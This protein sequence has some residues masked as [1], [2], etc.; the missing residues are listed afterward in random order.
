MITSD[1]EFGRKTRWTIKETCY[2]NYNSKT[3]WKN[4]L[5][6]SYILFYYP[7]IFWNENRKKKH[8]KYQ[9]QQLQEKI[10][11]RKGTV[12]KLSNILDMKERESQKDGAETGIFLWFLRRSRSPS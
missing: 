4:L 11:E 8:R 9:Q 1:R 6:F 10:M 12:P 2:K 3:N 7:P 5:N